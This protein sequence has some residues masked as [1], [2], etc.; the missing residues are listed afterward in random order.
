ME[1]IELDRSMPGDR[2]GSLRMK[3]LEELEG[4]V[5]CSRG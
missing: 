2:T 1:M 3:S 4:K 5:V